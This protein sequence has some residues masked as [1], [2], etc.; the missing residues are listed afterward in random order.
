MLRISRLLILLAL[1][2]PLYAEVITDGS[3]GAPLNLPGPDFQIEANLGQQMGGNL[4]HS[5]QDFNLQNHESAT[6][7]GPDSV[8]IIFSRVTGGNPSQINGTI[9]STIPHAELFL[10]NP[11]GIVFG[12]SARLDVQGG[13]HASTADYMRLGTTGRFEAR[14]PSQS[15]LTTAPPTAFG[16]VDAP[17]P[18]QV[19]GSDLAV[20]PQADFSLIGGDLTFNHAQLNAASGRFNLVSVASKGE[21]TS[22]EGRLDVRIPEM[23]GFTQLGH[24]DMLDSH[25]ET[26]GSP[27]GGI[28]IRGGQVWLH[29][30]LIH[31]HTL[32]ES[33]GKDI[34]ILATD[35]L[36]IQGGSA[37]LSSYEHTIANIDIEDS[38]GI[39][40]NTF[41]KG[42]A[43]HITI[44]TPHLEMRE[45]TIDASTNGEGDGGD[46]DI[47]SQQIRLEEGAEILSNTYGAGTSGQ[48]NL[49]ATERLD[50][51]DSR[52]FHTADE[53]ANRTIIQTN[54]FDT[55]DG[56]QIAIVTGHL[57]LSGGYILSNTTNQGNSGSI[58]INANRM[59][60]F[61]GSGITAGVL[62]QAIGYGGS[63]KINVADT[64]QLSGFRP[65]FINDGSLIIE[66]F[67]SAIAPA[68]LGKGFGGSLE[69]S[70]KNLI[71]SDYATIGAATMGI[72]MAGNMNIVVDNLYLKDG[73]ILTNSSGAIVG[74]ELWLATGD[75]GHI[76]VTA[77][78]NIVISGRNP[79]N[80]SSITSNTFLS[81]QGGN[82]NIQAN[83][84]IL[85]DGGTISANSL[86][87]GNAGNIHIRANQLSLT[88][89]GKITSD[90][91][92]AV[93]GSIT[94]FATDL[95]Y[96]RDAQLTTSVHGGKGNG[97][98]IT[99]ENPTLVVLDQSQIIAQADEGQGGNI[100]L[101]A[102]NFL[103]TPDSLIS[104]SSRLGIDGE[105]TINFL[106]ESVGG[107]LLVLPTGF[108][109]VSSLLPRPCEAMTLQEYLQRSSFR[110]NRLAGSSLLSPFDLKPSPPLTSTP[111]IS[112]SVL[113]VS[114][115]ENSL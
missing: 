112:K 70:T 48:I 4:F 79:F 11:A 49:Q 87:T 99:I 104:A 51:I 18:I 23:S 37:N 1:S 12:E 63:I 58:I 13:F 35:W 20:T 29:D 44:T 109:D 33:D 91:A 88:N 94:V 68:T 43:G 24:I 52:I 67:Q 59:E 78:E 81:A 85:T 60:V 66:N 90:A 10:L 31:A 28:S 17:K 56:G 21:V 97:G 106:D 53:I 32:G 26:S 30:S 64:I 75:G 14:V 8:N 80:P 46:I 111:N 27:A 16:F 39:I 86:G 72:G 82:L 69:I 40:S 50:L 110:V 108:I 115:K 93:G 45:S 25:I 47:H 101:V 38:V 92:Q 15:I 54:T 55:G 34:D 96:L 36:R 57:N 62:P 102:D 76:T 5:F 41:G 83:R 107:N 9:R 114:S 73:G 7:S 100:R 77:K 113:A 95:L 2:N 105:I 98:N 103:K 22:K 74:G 71:V 6:F 84:L 42:K 65:G 3:L 19:Q 89:G 61:N